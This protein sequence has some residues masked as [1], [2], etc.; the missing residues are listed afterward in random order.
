MSGTA[1]AP[2][3]I[4]GAGQAAG[5]AIASLRQEGYE[6]GIVLIGNEPY[7]PY[8]R[9]PLSKKFLAG[10]LEAERLYLKPEAFYAD[11]GV[12]VRLGIEATGIDRAA[13]T[14]SLSTAETLSYSKLLIATG[15]RVRK[16]PVPGA[17]L[18]GVFYLRSIEDVDHIRERFLAGGN[19][20]IVGGGYIG[21]EVA[22]VATK[23]GVSV[24]VIEGAD[25][26]M[27]RVVDPIVSAF[28]ER[29]HKEEG[30][31]ILTGATVQ[32]FE[33][34]DKVEAVVCGDG[35]RIPA[36]FV[37][38]GI[39]ILPNVELAEEAGLVVDNGIVV[40]ELCRTSDA[41]IFAAGDCTN[42]PN[43]IYG[44]RL[45]LESVPNAIEQGKTAA[46]MMLGKEKPYNQA[47]WFWSD[48]YDLKLQIVG[49][50]QGY[51]DAVVRGDPE[52]G[53]SFAVFYLKDGKLIAVDAVNR[54]PE[55]MMAKILVAKGAELDPARIRDEDIPVK[56][57]AG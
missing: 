43:G 9:P 33:G 48:Q 35:T 45:R 49:L 53:R 8:Q 1:G 13:H 17:E 31:T 14:V 4:L 12:D 57:L 23:S 18:D 34:G 52:A 29:V 5:Q 2:I 28:Y 32:A 19:M 55:F 44:R 42:H 15:S 16:L 3:V 54:A 11:A 24:T 6:G 22:A 41:D 46:A 30:V 39:G 20:V 50:S 21:L 10:E 27:A 56:Q 38:V 40:D 7:L 51:K 47:P 25:R 26:V 36:D 37:V